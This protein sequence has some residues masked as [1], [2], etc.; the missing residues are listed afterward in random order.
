MD[1]RNERVAIL[2][3]GVLGTAIARGLLEAGG[4]EVAATVISADLPLAGQLAPGDWVEFHTCELT[5]A[6]A[7]LREQE[8]AFA[9][10]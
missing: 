8:A 9:G 10:R 1:H 7:A 6:D 3:C 2:G 5:E 4:Y